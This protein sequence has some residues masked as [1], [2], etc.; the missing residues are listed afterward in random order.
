MSRSLKTQPANHLVAVVLLGEEPEAGLD[1]T[2]AQTQHLGICAIMDLFTQ[3]DF[4]G[5][6]AQLD[7]FKQQVSTNIGAPRLR[8]A[9]CSV[10]GGWFAYF[11]YLKGHK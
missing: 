4:S 6:V 7:F 3:L 11:V 2:T 1:H 9:G 10:M 5:F 8:M